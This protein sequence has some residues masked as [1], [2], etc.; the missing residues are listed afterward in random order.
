MIKLKEAR[1]AAGMTQAELARAV[2]YADPTADQTMISV[3]ERGEL[4]PGE[5]LRDAL[6]AV[7]HVTEAQLYDGVEAFFVPAQEKEFSD[8]TEILAAIFDAMADRNQKYITRGHLRREIQN[9][10]GEILSDRKMRRMIETARQ[11]GM[12]IANDQDGLGYFIPET[13]E[14]LK[15][16]F[17]QNQ[18]RALSILRQQKHIRRRLREK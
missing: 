9:W 16:L 17:N 6:C 1:K 4:Y 18:S 7:L 8:G 10:T 15:R 12:V 13:E 2:R 5:K 11:E 14:E 3:L